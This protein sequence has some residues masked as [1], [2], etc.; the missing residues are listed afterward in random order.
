MRVATENEHKAFVAEY[1]KMHKSFIA[2][3]LSSTTLSTSTLAILP[4]YL[5][6]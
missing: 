1:K 4:T 5:R 2:A 6:V 3:S